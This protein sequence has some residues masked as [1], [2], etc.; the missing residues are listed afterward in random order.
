MDAETKIFKEDLEIAKAIL[1]C[2][3]KVTMQYMYTDCYPM[4]KAFFNRYCTDCQNCR[5]FIDTIYVLIMAPGKRS[6]KAPLSNFRGESTLKTWLRNATMTYCYSCFRKRINTVDLPMS[7][8][9]SEPNSIDLDKFVGS[10]TIDMTELNR[11][12]DEAIMKTVLKKMPNKRYSELL[13]LHMIEKKPHA[14]IA[15]IMGMTMPNYYNRRK[16]AKD[17]YEQVKK[18]L[19]I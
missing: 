19:H 2:D 3:V 11:M 16:L 8:D 1:N 12:D 7:F 9:S 18:E 14:E 17:Q 6:K 15:E 4:F 5:E 13:R 10:T